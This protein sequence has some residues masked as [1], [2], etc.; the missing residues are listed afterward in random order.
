MNDINLSATTA[1]NE[2]VEFLKSYPQ[3]VNNMSQERQE[4]PKRAD[5]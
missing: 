4:V 2:F 1:C 3:A 5:L